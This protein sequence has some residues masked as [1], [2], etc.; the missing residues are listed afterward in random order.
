MM[1][2]KVLVLAILLFTV[3]SSAGNLSGRAQQNAGAFYMQPTKLRLDG[4][5]RRRFN[6]YYIK[7]SY[8]WEGLITEEFYPIGWSKDGKFAYYAEP[9]DEACGCYFG[10]LFI[11]DLK[12][13]KILWSY[14]YNGLD[15]QGEETKNTPKS[16]NDL[17]RKNRKLFSEKL[18]EHNIVPQGRFAF[19]NFPINY[20]GDQ[21]NADLKIKENKDEETIA[22][23]VVAQGTLQLISRRNGKKIVFD[24]NYVKPDEALPLDLK[25][26]GYV[27]S[28]F[29]E[30]IAVVMIEIYRGYEG[31]P[32]TT[33][34]KIV[35]S[36]L[37]GGFK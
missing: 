29:E 1:T 13:D 16:I 32:H 15:Y 22:Y 33:H 35:G 21:L 2:R 37:S 28:P 31:P 34:V 11:L 8:G 4:L 24:H 27:K 26:L 3:Y 20:Q 7:R 14:D 18:R 12:S 10:Q 23:G 30:R 19:L 17:W 25:V 6:E 36:S 9:A 5:I